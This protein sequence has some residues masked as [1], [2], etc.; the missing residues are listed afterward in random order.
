MSDE[1][2]KVTLEG[3]VTHM[4]ERLTALEGMY[5]DLRLLLEEGE[6]TR[7]RD[8]QASSGAGAVSVPTVWGSNGAASTP[9]IAMGGGGGV[10]VVDSRYQQM[11]LEIT[12][13]K[14]RLEERSKQLEHE[15][16]TS[17]KHRFAAAKA[18]SDVISLCAA[19]RTITNAKSMADIQTARSTFEPVWC[20]VLDNLCGLLAWKFDAIAAAKR[21]RDCLQGVIGDGKTN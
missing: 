21:S 18:R 3:R 19:V 9:V 1:R 7:R 12:A 5:G 14:G 17:E 16:G 11:E 10:K 20:D 13:L 15:R 4:S 8:R 6:A 2:D